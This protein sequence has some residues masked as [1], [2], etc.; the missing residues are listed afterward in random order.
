MQATT[1]WAPKQLLLQ[2]WAQ[3][4]AKLRGIYL[5]WSKTPQGKQCIKVIASAAFR[6]I[7]VITALTILL[8]TTALWTVLGAI[9]N[10]QNADQLANGYLFQDSATLHGAMFPGQHSFLFKWPLFYLLKVLGY[11]NFSL[12]AV[13]LLCV[14]VTV[15]ILVYVLYRIERRPLVFATLCL[16]LASVLLLVPTQ[17][18]AGGL[19]PVN[20]AMLTTRNIEYGLYILALSLLA[21]THKLA[22][23]RF[24]GAVA[25]LIVLIASDK[26]FLTLALGGGLVAMFIYALSGKWNLVTMSVNWLT[27][28]GVATLGALVVVAGVLSSG[29]THIVRDNGAGPYALVHGTKELALGTIYAIGSVFTN[30]G[31]NPAYDARTVQQIP[32]R[33]SHHLLSV[34][35]LSYGFNTILLLIGLYACCRLMVAS[36]T[37]NKTKVLKQNRPFKLSIALI[38]SSLAAGAAFIVTNHYYVV[39]ARYLTI[40]MF[41]VIISAATYFGSKRVRPVPVVLVGGAITLGMVASVYAC[42]HNFGAEQ[43]ALQDITARNTRVTQVLASHS[44]DVL[45]GDYWRVLP[46]KQQSLGKQSVLPLGNCTAPRQILSS[47][48]W[49]PD[50]HHK[51]FAY[52]LSLD[53]GLTDFPQCTL[54]KVIDEYGRPNGSFLV[55]GTLDKPTELVLFYD[56]GAH[57]SAPK[58]NGTA[59]Q[60]ATV[61]PVAPE[62]LPYTSCSVPTVMNIVAHQDD[63]L[64]FMSPDLLH[65]IKA[66]HCVRTVYM[67]AGDAGASSSYWIS[68]ERGSEEAYSSMLKT[69]DI[70]IDRIVKVGDNRYIT[71][72]NP[73]GNSHVSLIFMH[74]PD[75]NLGGQGFASVAN[76]SIARL[77]AG[78][79]RQI[80]SVDGQ[81]VYTADQVSDALT[82]LMH[83][84]QPAE[85]HTQSNVSGRKFVDHSDHRAT[86]RFVKRAYDNYEIEQFNNK[87]SVPI[88]YYIGYPIHERPENVSGTDLAEK[89]A[90]FFMYG[91]HDGSVCHSVKECDSSTVYYSYLTRQY[92]SPY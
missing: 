26:L 70:W 60:P 67:T 8:A 28:A 2:R 27:A 4:Q 57:H 92:Q 38:W 9:I 49:Q 68:R 87:I 16:A 22:S 15:A 79:I 31:A 55:A 77:E 81:S 44:V 29:V 62:D 71:V 5:R 20:M 42:V 13:T 41:A 3:P 32:V 78:Q 14:L 10:L 91:K 69:D 88:R 65:D 19:L 39:D 17:P 89:E 73:R 45:V 59:L 21:G 53:R 7:Y 43:A 51:R 1:K 47:K 58:A 25:L 33:A 80:D 90:A 6:R 63:D 66:G 48:A 30:F 52:L 35:G 82:T 84:Y 86:G 40:T 54:Q 50:L 85:I 74:L 61:V 64:L 75:G 56:R 72:S 37:S 83:L 36:L 11:S 18:Y 24:V 34:G 23:R 12:I 76:Q 46:I